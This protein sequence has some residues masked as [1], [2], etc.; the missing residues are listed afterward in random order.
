MKAQLYLVEIQDQDEAYGNLAASPVYM[1]DSTEDIIGIVVED[2]KKMGSRTI[3]LFQPTQNPDILSHISTIVAEE[4]DFSEIKPLID[5]AISNAPEEDRK[6]KTI[7]W[8]NI[9]AD[10][11]SQKESMKAPRSLLDILTKRI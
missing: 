7:L 5:L 8:E 4:L 3:C 1:N 10:L 6:V 11:K 9:Y 2:L